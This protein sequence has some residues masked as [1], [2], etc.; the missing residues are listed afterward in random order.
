MLGASWM[1]S[2]F[3]HDDLVQESRLSEDYAIHMQG[4]GTVRGVAT[5]QFALI[6]RPDAPV[7]WGRIEVTV[8]QQD[9]QPLSET[10]E[11]ERGTRVRV[12]EFSG[13]R[14]V[15]TRTLPTV[16]V[17]RPLDG[18]GEFTRIEYKKIDFSPNIDRGFFT[19]QRL[20]SL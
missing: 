20:K 3:T 19:L 8:R 4:R 13:H 17:M 16:M 18:S 11:D 5:Y 2:H 14:T 12:L 1:G 9:L 6:P 10:Y 15:G 7:V